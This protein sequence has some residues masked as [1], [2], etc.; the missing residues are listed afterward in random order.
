[1][2]VQRVNRSGWCSQVWVSLRIISTIP[3]QVASQQ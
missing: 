1:M 2:S 3:S